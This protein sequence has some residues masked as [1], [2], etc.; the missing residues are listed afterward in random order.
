MDVL[1]VDLDGIPDHAHEAA[2]GD[3]AFEDVASCDKPDLGNAE[4]LP[5]LCLAGID[6]ADL[7]RQ[8]ALHGRLDIVDHIVDDVVLPD[9]DLLLLGKGLGTRSRTDVEADD[10]R[11]R[12]GGKS[13]VAL[14]DGT[15]GCSDDVQPDLARAELLERSLESLDGTLDVT[16]VDD[17]EVLD[18]AFADLV[19]EVLES[20]LV[21]ARRIAQP[22]DRRSVSSCPCRRT[23]HAL[24]Q[25][26]F[27]RHSSRPG[28]EYPSGQ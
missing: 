10:E 17:V 3:L 26:R 11:V 24:F 13:D 12:G 14:D 23:W 16:L 4:D 25:D 1:L 9:L 28:G 21:R 7:R 19:V 2:S 20:D 22:L 6:L 8:H 15:R 5:D 27:Q 18:L